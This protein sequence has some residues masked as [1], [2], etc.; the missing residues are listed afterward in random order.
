MINDICDLIVGTESE[1][2]LRRY[3][4]L[5]TLYGLAMVANGARCSVVIP[6]DNK[7]MPI[8]VYGIG[9]AGSGIG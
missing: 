9:T 8:N 5:V 2:D 6:N 3:A 1:D 7:S 4:R